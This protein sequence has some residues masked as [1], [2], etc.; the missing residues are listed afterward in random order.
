MR[1][2]KGQCNGPQG[3]KAKAAVGQLVDTG[4]DSV[5]GKSAC[6][7]QAHASISLGSS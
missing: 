5:R 3:L 2:G 7:I 1:R 6:A 4:G